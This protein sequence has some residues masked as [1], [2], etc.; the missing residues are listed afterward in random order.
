ML[1]DVVWGAII[2][3]TPTT[4]I[5]IFLLM[6]GHAL[7]QNITNIH[8]DINS[9]VDQLLHISD[10]ERYA[11][12]REDERRSNVALQEEEIHLLQQRPPV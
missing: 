1:S 9:R 6:Q 10:Q 2:L 3:T 12:G 11:A 8:R 5:G 7:A 4:L